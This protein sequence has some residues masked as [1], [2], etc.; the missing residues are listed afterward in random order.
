MAAPNPTLIKRMD[1]EILNGITRNP[2]INLPGCPT[3]PYTIT[4][5]LVD[6]L[7]YGMPTLD[8]LGRPVAYYGQKVHGACP[9]R[10]MA[11]TTTLSTTG[12][13]AN[14]GCKGQATYANCPSRKWNN[15]VNWCINAG[16]E[17]IGCTEPTFPQMP[18][19]KY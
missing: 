7:L 17:C 3:H 13:Y 10:G 14:M 18:F 8:T 11:K 2:V 4:K 5:A 15:N 12:C 19:Y 6:L 9:R 16:Q 1:T